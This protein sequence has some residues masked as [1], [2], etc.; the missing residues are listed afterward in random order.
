MDVAFGAYGVMH[1]AVCRRLAL[2]TNRHRTYKSVPINTRVINE[3]KGSSIS[4]SVG[5][6]T[7]RESNATSAKSVPI[8]VII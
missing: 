4:V 5:K 7:V 1:T 6:A 3:R 2:Y 8:D